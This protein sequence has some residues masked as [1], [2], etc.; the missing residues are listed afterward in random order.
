MGCKLEHEL[1]V[2]GEGSADKNFLL[3]LCRT[4]IPEFKC[5]FPYPDGSG[6]GVSYFSRMLD[7][8]RGNR[9]GFN[10]LRGVVIV[11]D[12]GTDPNEV[13]DNIK[14]QIR[15]SGGYPVPNALSQVALPTSD[16]PALAVMLLPRDDVPGGL[17][18]LCIAELEE[19]YKDRMSC[20]DAFLNCAPDPPT[21]WSPEKLAKARYHVFV[22]GSFRDDPSRA[23]SH[24]FKEPNP[25]NPRALL[26]I[27]S[28]HYDATADRLRALFTQMM[29]LVP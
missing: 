26:K 3:K 29:P 10:R 8:L 11:A 23:I 19:N 7:G 12:S 27:D 1:V 24:A 25:Q 2:L 4:L 21:I 13:F 28:G 22:A 16:H 5:D 15:S 17:E 20:V 9:V 14:T 6:G 18:S